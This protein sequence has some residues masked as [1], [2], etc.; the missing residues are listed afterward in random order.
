MQL[1]TGECLAWGDETFGGKLSD[2][3][4]A[5]LAKGTKSVWSNGY[6]FLAQL[7]TGECLA[8]GNPK[9]GGELSD[10]HKAKLEKGIQSVWNT[11][12]AFLVQLNTGE[13]LA[14]GVKAG[15]GEDVQ[16]AL[17]EKGIKSVWSTGHAF[18]AQLGT[19]ECLVW[20]S[21]DGGA[22]LSDEKKALLA[23]GLRSGGSG[24]SV[25]S[26]SP[27]AAV[28]CLRDFDLS[29]LNDAQASPLLLH[30]GLRA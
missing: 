22:D 8:W 19:G 23:R 3:N 17:L 9:N 6:A 18:L 14:W 1:H 15:F 28:K 30:K 7:D 24:A 27:R 13:C 20:G 10:E 4:K 12:D 21:D 25:A 16:Q 5:K 11:A 29:K 2:E 26:G